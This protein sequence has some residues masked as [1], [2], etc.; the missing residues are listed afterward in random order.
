[1]LLLIL[2]LFIPSAPAPAPAA[3]ATLTLHI[4]NVRSS[5]GTLWVGIYESPADFLDRDKARLVYQPVHGTGATQ[6]RIDKL[7][8]GRRYAIAVFH[9]E[10]DNGELDTNLVGLPAEPW[11]FSRP[12][13]SWL[14]KPRF[15]EMSFVF[16]PR[17]GLPSLRLR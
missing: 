15:E 7:V 2:L 13:Q 11:A 10:N 3:L 6:V 5:S 9:D 12:L 1:M 4:E 17:H 16:D 8:V 14:R